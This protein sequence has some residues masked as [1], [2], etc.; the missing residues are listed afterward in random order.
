[1]AEIIAGLPGT[2]YVARRSVHDP[3]SIRQAKHAVMTALRAQIA[4]LGLSMVEFLSSCPTNWHMSP[5][6]ALAWI[7]DNMLPYFPA[8]DY[9]VLEAVKSLA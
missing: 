7:R 4:G 2:S 6:E 9:K 1:M 8:G 5:P 3:R